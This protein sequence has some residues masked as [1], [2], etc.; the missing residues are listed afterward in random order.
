MYTCVLVYFVINEILVKNLKENL[1]VIKCQKGEPS[2]YTCVLVY[3]VI[4]EILVKNLKE[5]LIV[6]KC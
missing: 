5:N 3:F 6:I 4:N 1:I 2:V